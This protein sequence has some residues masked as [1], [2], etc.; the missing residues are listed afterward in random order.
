MEEEN[1]NNEVI[2][3]PVEL[4]E[5]SIIEIVEE[6]DPEENENSVKGVLS[7]ELTSGK[8]TVTDKPEVHEDVIKSVREPEPLNLKPRREPEIEPKPRMGRLA[9]SVHMMLAYENMYQ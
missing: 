2:N 9:Q 4:V 1:D 8:L 5:E 6:M 7:E 3:V